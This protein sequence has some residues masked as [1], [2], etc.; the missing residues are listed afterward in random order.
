MIGFFDS[1]FGGLTIL[2][3]VEKLLPEYSYIYLGDN[4]R[5]PYGSKSST[6]I[7]EHT[8]AGVEELFRQGADLIVLACNTASAVALRKIQQELLPTKYPGKKVLGIIFPTAEEAD[9]F[10]QT[11]QICLWATEMTV[12]SNAYPAEIIKIDP[13]VKLTQLACPL[14]VPMIETGEITG[15]KLESIINEYIRQTIELNPQTDTVVLGCTHYAIIEAEI[16]R[17]L[18]FKIKLVTQGQIVAKK[19]KQYLSNHPEIETKLDR[20]SKKVFLT[21]KKSAQVKR[22]TEL[23]Y[24]QPVDLKSVKGR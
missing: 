22:L 3:E 21:T 24:G 4:A 20:E 5:A 11:K 19:L 12:Q 15:A 8:V 23:F 10:S 9:K 13:E 2:K 1:G 18:P 16:R 14:F 7:Y 6:E 17:L